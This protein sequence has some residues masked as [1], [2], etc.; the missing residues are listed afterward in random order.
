M[1]KNMKKFIKLQR[2]EVTSNIIYSRVAQKEKDPHN[3]EIL[4]KMAE[5]E[6]KHAGILRKYT[7]RDVQ[8]YRWQ[9]FWYKITFAVF[10]I[11]FG[12]KLLEKGEDKAIEAYSTLLDQYPDIQTIITDEEQHEAY[13]ISLINEERLKYIGSVVLGLNDALVELTGALAG[14]TF[15]IQNNQAIAII[16][17]ITGISAALSMA[18]SEYLSSKSDEEEKPLKS[19]LYTGVAYIIT[20]VLLVLP[21][22]LIPNSFIALGTTVATTILIIA[23]FNYYVSITKDQHFFKRFAEMAILSLSITA[24]SFGI[25]YVINILFPKISN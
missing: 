16:G 7:K 11:T 13:L 1:K 22:V 2:D 21:F 9:L 17:S 24:I 6:N 10:G 19:A 20:V 8:P 3:R 5:E 14:F 25:G 4:L 23:M 12:M 18:A 15:A